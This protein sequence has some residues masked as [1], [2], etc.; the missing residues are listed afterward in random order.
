MLILLCASAALFAAVLVLT[1]GWEG[2]SS[3]KS[4]PRHWARAHVLGRT[5]LCGLL[6]SVA[7]F[8]ATRSIPIAVLAA[9]LMPAGQATLRLTSLSGRQRA[10]S[11]Q[12]VDALTMLANSLRAGLSLTQG[13]QNL[14]EDLPSPLGP[15]FRHLSSELS[16]GA[17][18]QDSLTNLASRMR[19]DDIHL[20][21]TAVLVQRQT[22]GNLSAVFAS[23]AGTIRERHKLTAKIRAATAQGRMSGAVIAG[24]PPVMAVAISALQPGFFAPMTQSLEGWGLIALM[25][26]MDIVGWIAISRICTIAY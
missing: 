5:A 9:L 19:N 15:E 8:M 13:L 25:V 12:L 4:G 16:F 11:S 3:Q 26:T 1:S 10:V 22:G 23:L 21:V 7:A 18:I 20:F 14:A 6:A 2:A 24:L 17:S